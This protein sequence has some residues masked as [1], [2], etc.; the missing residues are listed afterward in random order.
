MKEINVGIIGLGGRGYGNLKTIMDCGSINIVA[1]CDVYEDRIERAAK[2]MEERGWKE[3]KKTVD[4]REILNDK[5]VNTVFVFSSWETHVRIAIEAMRAG[6]AVGME[7]GGAY[8]LEECFELVEAWE[9]TKVPLMMLENCCFGKKELL[10]LNLA[11]AGLLGEI[12]YCHGAYAHDLREEVAK[13]KENRHY[14]LENYKHRNCENYPTHE[15]GPIAKV[16]DINRGNKMNRLVSVATKAAGLKKYIDDRKDTIENKELIGYDF[17]QADIVETIITCENGEVISIRLDTTLPRSYN[18]EFTLRGTAG[19]YEE[20][21]NSVFLDGDE[22]FFETEKYAAIAMNNA[23]RFYHQ[24]IPPY[25]SKRRNNNNSISGH[26]GLDAYTFSV[27]FHCLKN[28]LPMPIDVYDAAS[29]MAITPLSEQSIKTGEAVEIP[30]F[31]KGNWKN[32]DRYDV[33]EIDIF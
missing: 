16:V 31:T 28:D 21:T 10:G 1:I 22:E 4:Y 11:R 24:Y 18:R 9:E 20:A 26:G 27:F 17:K 29:W 25:W 33:T 15:L 8:H 6:K 7:V 32:R 23:E 14:R 2:E 19:M 30:D 13:G 12:V 3:P 5:E